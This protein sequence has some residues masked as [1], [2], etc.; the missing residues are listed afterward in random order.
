LSY[1]KSEPGVAASTCVSGRSRAERLLRL[2]SWHELHEADMG[3]RLNL[4]RKKEDVES[5]RVRP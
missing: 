4:K 3:L 1:E 2:C 5:R